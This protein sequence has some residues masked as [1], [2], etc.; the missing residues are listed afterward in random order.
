MSTSCVFASVRPTCAVRAGQ[1]MIQNSSVLSGHTILSGAVGVGMSPLSAVVM[2]VT[3]FAGAAQLIAYQLMAT[4]T[5]LLV[6]LL[7]IVFVNLRMAHYS[8]V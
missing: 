3:V 6:I 8:L 2:S 7:A 4:S 5:S 1:G